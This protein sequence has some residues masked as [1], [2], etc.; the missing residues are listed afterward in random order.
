MNKWFLCMIILLLTVSCSR[1]FKED[2]K[3]PMPYKEGRSMS[4]VTE[5]LVGYFQDQQ[6]DIVKT[7]NPPAEQ[8]ALDQFEKM[9]GRKLPQDFR[10]LYMSINGQK[11]EKLPMLMNGYELLSLEE[12]EINWKN[13]KT[14][15]ANRADYR[16]EGQTS[17]PVRS[18]WWYPMWIPFA[19]TVYGGLLLSGFFPESGRKNRPGH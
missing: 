12:I 15:N 13:M 6:P 18:F 1:G 2:S 10:M 7:F 14:M 8:L 9:V 3:G 5:A 11:D 19:K 4:D 16:T 17:G